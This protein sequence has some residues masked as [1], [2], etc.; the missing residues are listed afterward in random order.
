MPVSGLR[1][2]GWIMASAVKSVEALANVCFVPRLGLS[3]AVS[4]LTPIEVVRNRI[5]SANPTASSATC[6]KRVKVLDKSST[7]NSAG[8][9]TAN[10]R[11][12]VT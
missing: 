8:K 3:P 2:S 11:E 7:T 1:R 4:N 6:N 5:Y 12:M 10:V 9:P